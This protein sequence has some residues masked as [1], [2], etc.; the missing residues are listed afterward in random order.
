MSLTGQKIIIE[1]ADFILVNGSTFINESVVQTECSCSTLGKPCAPWNFSYPDLYDEY[2]I[3]TNNISQ[4]INN[5]SE[6]L[7]NTA[8][9]VSQYG[10]YINSTTIKYSIIG[11]FS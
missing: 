9:F 7:I 1:A 6:L 5:M 8:T 11:L 4:Q 2:G 10:L 3:F